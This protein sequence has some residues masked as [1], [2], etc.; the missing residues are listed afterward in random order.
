MAVELLIAPPASGKTESCIQRIQELGIEKPLARIWVIVP[1]RLQA[2]AYRKRLA[3]AGGA[4][5]VQVGRFEDLY[6]GILE[7]AGK[8]IP[9]ASF[10]ML[11]RLVQ[12]TVDSSV[13]QGELLKFAPLQDLPGFITTLREIFAELKRGL[14]TPEQFT[15]YARIGSDTHKD[16]ATLYSRYQAR[17]EELNWADS[18]SFSGMAIHLMEQQPSFAASIDLLI[19]DG[20]DSFNG[21]Q[22]QALKCF[23]AQVNEMLITFPGKRTSQRTAHRRF[24]DSIERLFCEL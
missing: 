13:E 1:D 8:F 2:A 19:V 6:Q 17:L 16:L 24:T 10:P 12:E 15:E 21:A 9:R 14:V 3:S 5:G 7:H 23:S 20:F 22:Y 11:H 18:E 4:L